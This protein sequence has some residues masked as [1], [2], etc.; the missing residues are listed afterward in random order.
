MFCLRYLSEKLGFKTGSGALHEPGAGDIG[1]FRLGLFAASDV[2]Q[3]SRVRSLGP[4][5][6]SKVGFEGFDVG[7]G[8]LQISW[9]PQHYF[10]FFWGG[11]S[12]YALRL[13]NKPMADWVSPFSRHSQLL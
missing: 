5:V 6:P 1:S 8:S 9:C 10:F 2:F 12:L 11:G 13:I 4:M 7:H 3:S